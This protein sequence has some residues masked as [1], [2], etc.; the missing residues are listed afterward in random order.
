MS[1]ITNDFGTGTLLDS[2]IYQTLGGPT[3]SPTVVL[4]GAEGCSAGTG[5]E[6][7]PRRG[8]V[9]GNAGSKLQGM[10]ELVF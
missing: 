3:L 4:R 7:L 6:A 9:S 8:V 2:L 10:S 5:T 1:L